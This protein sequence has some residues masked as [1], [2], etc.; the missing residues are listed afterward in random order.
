MG[1]INFSPEVI[2]RGRSYVD[3][4]VSGLNRV[5]IKNPEV[6]GYVS[7]SVLGRFVDQK[8]FETY[9]RILNQAPSVEKIDD[10]V[11]SIADGDPRKIFYYRWN[12]ADAALFISSALGNNTPRYRDRLRPVGIHSYTVLQKMMDDL[13]TDQ[14]YWFSYLN[15]YFDDFARGLEPV[16]KELVVPNFQKVSNLSDADIRRLLGLA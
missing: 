1:F 2:E 5:G 10:A 9:E 16:A 8:L 3:A 15:K 12:L 4:V 13:G 7:F 14:A 6:A 11:E